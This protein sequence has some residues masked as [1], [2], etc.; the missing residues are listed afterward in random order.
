[1]AS[2]NTLAGYKV[3]E[4]SQALLSKQKKSRTD[5]KENNE[6]NALFSSPSLIQPQFVTV[7]TKVRGMKFIRIHSNKLMNAN[8]H[9]MIHSDICSSHFMQFA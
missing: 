9:S 6:L 1:M 8:D 3:G 7:T 2:G 5:K 4:I